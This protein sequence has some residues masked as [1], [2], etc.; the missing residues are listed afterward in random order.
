V[1]DRPAFERAPYGP[2]WGEQ[3][4]VV[5][6]APTSF[7]VAGVPGEMGTWADFGR[8]YHRLKETRDELSPRSAQ[9][10]RR[11]VEG[12]TTTRDTFRRLYRHLQKET[13]YVSVQLGIGG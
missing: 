5:R 8:W 6:V 3:A 2:S 11:L 12:A 1:S 4:P 13:R 9:R 7:E 10:M